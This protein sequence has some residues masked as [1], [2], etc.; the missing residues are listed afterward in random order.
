MT[1]SYIPN[2][3]LHLKFME[4]SINQMKQAEMNMNIIYAGG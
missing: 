3:Y 4:I 2:L 1:M